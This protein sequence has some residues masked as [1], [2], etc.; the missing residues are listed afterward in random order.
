M[1]KML[2]VI[3]F[4][5]AD[6]VRRAA[7]QTGYPVVV[8]E[9]VWRSQEDGLNKVTIYTDLPGEDHT[10]FFDAFEALKEERLDS[11]PSERSPKPFGC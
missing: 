10:P 2:S 3:N 4:N 6:L 5:E 7:T 1:A 8:G 11:V 9:R